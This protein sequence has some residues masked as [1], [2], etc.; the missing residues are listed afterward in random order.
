MNIFFLLLKEMIRHCVES[1]APQFVVPHK[2]E[3]Q[4]ELNPAFDVDDFVLPFAHLFALQDRLFDLRLDA[5]DPPQ[6]VEVVDVEV[7]GPIDPGFIFE[8]QARD[9]HFD[10]VTKRHLYS[11]T[12]SR[13]CK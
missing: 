9:P 3:K 7:L 6:K 8:H 13:F 11:W 12:T 2:N 5:L 10:N 4:V 1:V